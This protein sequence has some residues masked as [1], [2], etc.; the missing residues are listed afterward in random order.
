MKHYPVQKKLMNVMAEADVLSELSVCN[1][2]LQY[3]LPARET[4]FQKNSF[5]VSVI[6]RA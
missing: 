3:L 4:P 6:Q 5:R 2:T 1:G